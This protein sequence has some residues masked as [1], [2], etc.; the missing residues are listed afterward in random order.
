MT[1]IACAVYERGERKSRYTIF[2]DEKGGV[3]CPVRTNRKMGNLQAM[4]KLL[5][6]NF[7]R[8]RQD[9]EILY[10]EDFHTGERL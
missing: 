4:R 1:P 2:Q 5:I 7:N 8:V 6:E 3:H 9:D 10:I